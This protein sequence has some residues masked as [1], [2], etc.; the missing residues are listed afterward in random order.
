MSDCCS[1]VRSF[2]R[3]FVCLFV[4]VVVFEFLVVLILVCSYERTHVCFYLNAHTFNLNV[5]VFDCIIVEFFC[6]WLF[7]HDGGSLLFA[8]IFHFVV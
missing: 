5:D 1:S 3:L 7:C 2:V 6:V 4:C 8:V